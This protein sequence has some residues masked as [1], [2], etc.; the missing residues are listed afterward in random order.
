MSLTSQEPQPKIMTMS[1]QDTT[2]LKIIDTL[3]EVE[4]N[5]QIADESNSKVAPN[6]TNVLEVRKN[7]KEFRIFL[8]LIKSGKLTTAIMA[9]KVVGVSRQT[10]GKWLQTKSAKALLDKELDDRLSTISKSKDWKAHAYIIDKIT[11]EDKN[12]DKASVDLKQLIYI[13]TS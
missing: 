10:I 6:V 13:N 8:K 2:P 12:T 9:S 11:E 7:K 1:E 3:S 4:P 5:V